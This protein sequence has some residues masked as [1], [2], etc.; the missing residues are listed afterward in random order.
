MPRRLWAILR[1]WPPRL[2]AEV[3]TWP[4][5]LWPLLDPRPVPRR[6]LRILAASDPTAILVILG[7]LAVAWGVALLDPVATFSLQSFAFLASLAPE[8][9]WGTAAVLCGVGQMVVTINGGWRVRAIMGICDAM[10][11]GFIALG[12][13]LSPG[14][15]PVPVA[16]FTTYALAGLWGYISAE[17]RRARA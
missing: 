16:Q 17:V 3:R 13:G 14:G 6:L 15:S 10:F 1:S 5:R 4:R 7:L 12:M 8:D 11:W 2:V 9:A